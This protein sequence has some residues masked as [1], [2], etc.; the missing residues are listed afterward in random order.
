MTGEEKIEVELTHTDEMM[1]DELRAMLGVSRVRLTLG[2]FASLSLLR[3][4]Y[5]HGG[6]V[7]EEALATAM[8]LVRHEDMS[9]L[10]FHAELQREMDAAFRAFETIQ[11]DNEPSGGKTSDILP[12]SP[13]WF[14][15]IIAS[16][17]QSMPSITYKQAWRDVPMTMLTHLAVS[18]ARRG[19]AITARPT[20]IKDALARFR[21]MRRKETD[22]ER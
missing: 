20:D 18:T 17:C 22:N 11:P 21:E 7:T 5:V 9:P 16:A 1:A 19:G 13:E 8:D 3:S 15:D 6:E 10:E 14:A 4:P 2:A 12:F